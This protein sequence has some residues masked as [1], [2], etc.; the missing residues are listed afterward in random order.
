MFLFSAVKPQRHSVSSGV[1]TETS[2]YLL[3]FSLVTWV[4]EWS[5]SSTRSGVWE[6]QLILW[7]VV[8]RFRR[9]SEAGEM[10]WHEPHEVQ[11]RQL[12]NP[13]SGIEQPHATVQA[14]TSCVGSYFEGKHLREHFTL[15]SICGKVSGVLWQVFAIKVVRNF[16]SLQCA[17]LCLSQSTYAPCREKKV[18]LKCNSVER[19]GISNWRGTKLCYRKRPCF[20]THKESRQL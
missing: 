15:F 2:Q 7:R 12:Q 13:A 5:A 10:G 20:S 4:M 19:W 18:F 8:L 16:S 3:T 11:P 6:E 14:G 17:C 9:T 1:N